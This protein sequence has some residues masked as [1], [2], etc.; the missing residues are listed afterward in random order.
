MNCQICGKPSGFYPLCGECFKLRDDGKIIKCDKC[1]TWHFI[2]KPCKCKST[3][4]TV[5]N[6]ISQA[7]TDSTPKISCLICGQDSNGMHFCKSCYAKYKDRAIDVR[8]S[9]CSEV[10][11][12]DEYGNKTQKCDDGFFV[13][14]RAEMIITNWLFSHHVRVV[15]EP[16]FFYMEDGECKTLHPDFSLPDFDNLFIE[17][18]ELT[19]KPYLR[20]KEYTQKV[21]SDN[22]KK[23]LVMDDADLKDI[24][25]FFFENLGIR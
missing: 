9:K 21:Y 20:K 8:I 16:D 23:V 22:G 4:T 18:C 14:S 11:V 6:K 7:K 25:R 2:G 5:T 17:Y 10:I 13:R 19:N 15:H 1:N 24:A 12:L 3:P